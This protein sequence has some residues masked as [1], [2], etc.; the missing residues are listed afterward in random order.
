MS[1]ANLLEARRITKIYGQKYVVNEVSLRV[2]RGE[3]VGLLGRKDAGKTTVFN[4]LTGQLK[5][6]SG[7]TKILGEVLTALPQND[8]VAGP[9]VLLLDEP[10]SGLAPDKA[11]ELK[12]RIL[13]LVGKGVGVLFTD[14]DVRAALDF[15]DRA[16]IL[17]EGKVLQSGRS[18]LLITSN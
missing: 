1:D 9:A 13:R 5:P 7:S 10:F 6:D 17:Y 2:D 18:S 4:M 12:S 11:D 14:S 3:I 8:A 15:C 16:Y